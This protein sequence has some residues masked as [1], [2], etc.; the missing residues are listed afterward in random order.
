MKKFAFIVVA[1]MLV[2]ALIPAVSACGNADR[3]E[4]LH[5]ELESMGYTLAFED[6]FDGDEIDYTKWRVSYNVGAGED[7]ALRRAGYYEVSDDTVDVSDGVLTVSTL[8]KDGQYGEGWYTCWL[9]SSVLGSMGSEAPILCAEEDYRGF[10]STYG[11]FEV[12]CIAPP[13]EGIWSA[14]WMMPNSE[15]MSGLGGEPGGADGV[16]VDVMESPYYYWG[17][18]KRD[19]VRHV[20]HGDGYTYNK[21]ESSEDI[22]VRDMYSSFHTYGVLWT[23]TEYVFYVDGNETWRTT[24]NVDGEHMGVSH[25]PQYMIL[26]VEV[27]GYAD[28]DVPVPG[29]N[30]DGTP[31]WCGDPMNNDL[32]KSYGFV[33]DYVKVYCKD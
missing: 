33:I 17:A 19:N 13:C 28:G 23:E 22:R 29:K 26:S 9:E 11:Y 32:T 10:E 5:A 20:L 4:E 30:N 15:G 2:A 24:Y 8:Y 16:E 7:G 3:T 25:V 31:Y 18:L 6:N 14:F 21:T 12:R 1:A 27:A